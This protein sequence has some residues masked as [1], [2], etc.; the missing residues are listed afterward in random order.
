MIFNFFLMM[1]QEVRINLS[2]KRAF[3]ES[4]ISSLPKR[5]AESKDVLYQRHTITQDQGNDSLIPI[6]QL[7]H[8]IIKKFVNLRSHSFASSIVET[9]KRITSTT[10]DKKAL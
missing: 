8:V 6:D 7:Y 5:V 1:E 9:Y 10:L 3:I 2:L 4:N